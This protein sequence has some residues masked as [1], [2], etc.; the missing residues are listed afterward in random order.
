MGQ[1]SVTFLAVAGA[2]L[3]CNQHRSAL[4][5]ARIDEWLAHHRARASAKSPLGEALA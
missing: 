2:I 1:F 3:S 4:I 5:L